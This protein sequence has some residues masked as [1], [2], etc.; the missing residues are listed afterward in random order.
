MFFFLLFALS[1]SQSPA[2]HNSFR[3]MSFNLRLPNQGDGINYWDHRRPLVASTIRYHEPDIIGVQEAFRRQLDEMMT[4]M[5]EY[6]WFG[7]CSLNALMVI[8]SG[9]LKPPRSLDQKDG[10]P[11]SRVL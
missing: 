9:F 2:Q 11:L 6:T 10:M 7:V 1:F 5:P 4:D 3:V 8:P